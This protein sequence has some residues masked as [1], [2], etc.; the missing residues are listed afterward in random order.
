MLTRLQMY[1][2]AGGAA[3]ALILGLG[4]YIAHLRH[5]VREARAEAVPA[6]ALDKVAVTTQ[7]NREI[8][9]D[10]VR[11]IEQAPGGEAPVAPD[12]LARHRDGIER[13]RAQR[14]R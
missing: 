9:D 8:A 4:A 3:V 6:K 7:Q 2:A 5:E 1:L 14:S 13:L 11:S 12:V 10:A